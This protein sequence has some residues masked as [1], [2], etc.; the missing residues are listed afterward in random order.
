MLNTV[1]LVNTTSLNGVEYGS[2]K[3]SLGR[4]SY[5]ILTTIKSGKHKGVVQ[6]KNIIKRN[7]PE[8]VIQ[9]LNR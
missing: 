2:K 8:I 1:S 7:V 5:F 3:D 6:W 9:Q 4:V